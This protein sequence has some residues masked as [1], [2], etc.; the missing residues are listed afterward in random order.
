MNLKKVGL[1]LGV[2]V[3]FAGCTEPTGACSTAVNCMDQAKSQCST[4]QTFTAGKTCNSLG[5]T[6][7]G[8]NGIWHKPH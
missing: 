4:G 7:D 1:A 3:L 6:A 8:A 5:Y 2:V